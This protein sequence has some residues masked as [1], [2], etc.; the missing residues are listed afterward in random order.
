MPDETTAPTGA[1]VD[2]RSAAAERLADSIRKT[3]EQSKTEGELD[4]AIADGLT[5]E[6]RAK[7]GA[8]HWAGLLNSRRGCA[9]KLRSKPPASS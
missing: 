8:A 3:F 1:N 6:N 7:I 2:A 9:E 4:Q 5:Q